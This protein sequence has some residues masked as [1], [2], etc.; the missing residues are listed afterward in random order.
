MRS[1]SARRS[2]TRRARICCDA[3][4]RSVS[5]TSITMLSM[6]RTTSSVARVARANQASGSAIQVITSLS[7]RRRSPAPSW[8]PSWPDAT[9]RRSSGQGRYLSSP[10]AAVQDL[11]DGQAD[12]QPNEVG[13]RQRPHRMP[14][15][16][17][18]DGV[19]C[20][21]CADPLHDGV[22][23]LV[24][25][26]HQDPVGDEA[27][28]VGC[29]DRRLAQL[30]AE[31]GGGGHRIGRGRVAADQLDQ[32]HERDRVHEVHAQDPV[33]APGG[34]AQRGD[35]NGRRVR[36]QD[37][38]GVEHPVECPEQRGLGVCILDDRLDDVVRGHQ[39]VEIG[40]GREPPARRV[41][42]IGRERALL[43]ESVQAAADGSG[44]PIERGRHDILQ[45]D[46]EAGLREDLG[47]AVPHGPRADDTDRLD[48]SHDRSA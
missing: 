28:V 25:H 6:P 30:P 27:G 22:D 19:D 9:I 18:H 20:L 21:R 10:R 5:T 15:A 1:P 14:H 12:I 45:L 43:H 47:D 29:L 42:R 37:G 48:V 16:E 36:C 17:R 33:G 35:R 46:V 3:G 13:E 38:V 24:D 2:P 32:R 11:H 23:R 26:R 34:G 31:R 8:R 7:D 44:R 4:R 40:A 39:G 41:G